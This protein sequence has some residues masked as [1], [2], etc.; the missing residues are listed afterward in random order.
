VIPAPH[1]ISWDVKVALAFYEAR[2]WRAVPPHLLMAV[3]ML[4]NGGGCATCR[5]AS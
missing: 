5:R 3:Q 4:A 1:S 2:G